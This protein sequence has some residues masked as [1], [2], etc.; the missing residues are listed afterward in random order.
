MV[1]G[2]TSL[3]CNKVNESALWQ[4]LGSPETMLTGV[5]YQHG[6]GWW[7]GQRDSV[8]FT[9]LQA[10]HWVFAGTGLAHGAT[11]RDQNTEAIVGYECDGAGIRQTAQGNFVLSHPGNDPAT[12]QLLGVG[13]VNS[14]WDDDGQG[15]KQR[16]SGA[17]A[18]ATMGI[19]GG[20]GTGTA[21]SALRPIGRECLLLVQRRPPDRWSSASLRTCSTV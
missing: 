4:N 1:D 14:D 5:S 21:F 20:A 8:G 10:D 2:D 6:G 16:R 3:T 11:F 12:F 18:A 7:T 17:G 13:L 15:N 9:V 19:W